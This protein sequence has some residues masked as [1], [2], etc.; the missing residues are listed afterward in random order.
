M[1]ICPKCGSTEVDLVAGGVT[2]TYQCRKCG[3]AGSLFPEFEKEENGKKKGKKKEKNKR[4][5]K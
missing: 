2:G 1:K 3:F 4:K 5:E